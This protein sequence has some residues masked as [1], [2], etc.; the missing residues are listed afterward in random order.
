MAQSDEEISSD[1]DIEESDEEEDFSQNKAVTENKGGEGGI[2]ILTDEELFTITKATEETNAGPTRA[3]S[4]AVGAGR[5]SMARNRE[6][7][8]TTFICFN[9]DA[10]RD[11]LKKE[12]AKNQ[13]I[14]QQE[15]SI[16][17]QATRAGPVR[18]A[19]AR[20]DT[21]T[22]F[23]CL[24]E[25][26]FLQQM[27]KEQEIQ[28]KLEQQGGNDQKQINQQQRKQEGAGI[29]Q[30]DGQQQGNAPPR[31]PRPN[32]AQTPNRGAGGGQG[33]PGGA[34]NEGG[35]RQGA[36][37]RF[38]TAPPPMRKESKPLSQTVNAEPTKKKMPQVYH[39]LVNTEK[40]YIRDLEIVVN[41][42]L[43]KIR[44]NKLLNHY[45]IVSLFSNIEELIPVNKKLLGDLLNLDTCRGVGELFQQH[46]AKFSA[47][48]L[49][50]SNQPNIHELLIQYKHDYPE[51]ND[52]L[53]Q[54]LKKPECRKQDLESFLI[55]PL[56]RL[57]KYPLLLKELVSYEHRSMVS[58]FF[59]LFFFFS[60]FFL[61]FFSL[62]HSSLL[63]LVSSLPFQC[64]EASLDFLRTIFWFFLYLWVV[65][66]LPSPYPFLFWDR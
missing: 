52:F 63:S 36:G 50:C 31:P 56:Q 33:V 17:T 38:G 62:P 54:N 5:A 47:Y 66:S 61:S 43:Q 20:N 35:T 18:S 27:L 19:A 30:G 51:F 7:T 2:K 58:F 1:S 45:E 40:D 6:N 8:R 65:H 9:E 25:Q 24:N 28:N 13:A 53:K 39:E 14:K 22:T 37:P 11:Q 64:L 23:I 26:A 10:F 12:E 49:Y 34:N 32:R 59:P 15:A 16:A 57:C 44:K 41:L 3:P 48:A 60:F 29:P 21:R 46:A 42:F 4:R 55:M